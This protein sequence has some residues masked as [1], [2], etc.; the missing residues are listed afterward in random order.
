MGQS[1]SDQR[2]HRKRV[3]GTQEGKDE[4]EKRKA[5]RDNH[6]STIGSNYHENDQGYWR[7]K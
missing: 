2:R 7:H 5:R 6:K 3:G 1:R 4:H